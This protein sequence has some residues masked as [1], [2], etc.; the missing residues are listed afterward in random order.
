M[1]KL[2]LLLAFQKAFLPPMRK[3]AILDL[4]GMEEEVEEGVRDEGG[5][6]GVGGEEEAVFLCVSQGLQ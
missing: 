4:L 5:A 1:A 2:P 6:W 3:T